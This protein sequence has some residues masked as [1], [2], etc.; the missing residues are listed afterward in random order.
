MVAF[1][2]SFA[3]SI[4]R[5][6]FAGAAVSRAAAPAKARFSMDASASVP[7][8]E[9]PPKLDGSLPG[10]VGFDPCGFSNAFELNFLREAE[11]KHGRICMLAILGW[12]FPELVGHLPN[13]AYSAT[14]P[15]YAVGSVGWLPI[16]QIL[17]FIAICEAKGVAKVYDEN[18]ANPGTTDSTHS[19]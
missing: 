2:S 3:P 15:L 4:A 11:L 14:N 9:R 17:A 13:E 18:C 6:A 19:A 10:D 5:T 1:V 8:L 16:I 7:F 12:V